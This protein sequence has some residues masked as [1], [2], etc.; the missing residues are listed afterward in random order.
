MRSAGCLEA[1]LCACGKIF[2]SVWRTQWSQVPYALCTR[3]YLRVLAR[4][5]ARDSRATATALD[6]EQ[7][8]INQE[9]TPIESKPESDPP[10]ALELPAH[11]Q[12]DFDLRNGY[13]GEI[14]DAPFAWSEDS[15]A[16]PGKWKNTRA[17]LDLTA[18]KVTMLGSWKWL[19][20]DSALADKKK[21][22]AKGVR[23]VGVS[24]G[25]SDAQGILKAKADLT[26]LADISMNTEVGEPSFGVAGNAGLG[27]NA[28]SPDG[29][30]TV[31]CLARSGSTRLFPRG[32]VQDAVAYLLSGG[33]RIGAAVEIWLSLLIG[34]H[35]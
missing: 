4:V 24:A 31:F 30:S 33:R 14:A 18:G 6:N 17:K 15:G 13:V 27:V 10:A 29:K 5:F 22:D 3:G 26:L 25:E 21:W 34:W 19:A 9:F 1:N 28:D 2:R 11:Y 20:I 16:I 8:N 7:R 32:F 12:S 35:L 23:L